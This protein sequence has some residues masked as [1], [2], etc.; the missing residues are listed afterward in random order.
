[1]LRS[2]CQSCGC[3]AK[4]EEIKPRPTIWIDALCINQE[5]TTN[6][7]KEG[8]IRLMGRIYSQAD[9]V[10]MWLG[11]P[12][13]NVAYG[14]R[15]DQISCPWLTI[16]SPLKLLPM[17]VFLEAERHLSIVD[18]DASPKL[19]IGGQLSLVLYRLPFSMRPIAANPNESIS[20]DPSGT[21]TDKIAELLA[22]TLR[23]TREANLLMDFQEA[24]TRNAWHQDTNKEIPVVF[25]WNKRIKISPYLETKL[26]G[27]EWP[28]CG[29]FVLVNLLA[30]D[31]H[32]HDLSFLGNDGYSFLHDETAQAWHKS[33]FELNQI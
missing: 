32:F 28:I 20:T 24:C 15:A 6:K 11:E 25:D 16:S 9:T 5:N 13:R 26:S 4:I 10:C 22:G 19:P 23:I 33:R 7:E 12:I 2:H 1:M 21:R 29:A 14:E 31:H 3:F 27:L 18:D 17:R 30:M 8:Q